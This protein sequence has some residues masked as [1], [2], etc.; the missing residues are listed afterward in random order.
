MSFFSK[1]FGGGNSKQA[2]PAAEI[3]YEGYSILSTPMDEGGQYRVC[4]LIRKEVGG[5]EC[6]HRLIR[7]DMCSSVQEASDLA[8]QKSRQLIDQRGEKIFD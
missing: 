7:A 8:V 2:A 6:E 4:A 1:L 5:E 3:E